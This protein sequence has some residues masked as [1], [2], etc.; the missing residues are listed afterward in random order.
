MKESIAAAKTYKP[1]TCCKSPVVNRRMYK[2][3]KGFLKIEKLHQAI[4]GSGVEDA[5]LDH[6]F[7]KY[8]DTM[9]NLSKDIA[10]RTNG[11]LMKAIIL[12]LIK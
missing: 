6:I 1:F 7:L 9:D 10:K 11:D 8:L 3:A 12:E 5:I 4:I 2:V